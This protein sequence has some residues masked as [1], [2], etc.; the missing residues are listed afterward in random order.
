MA[1]KS[2]DDGYAM[3]P[4]SLLI[5]PTSADCNLNCTYCFYLEKSKLYPDTKRHRMSEAVLESMIAKYMAT[6]QPVYYFGWQGGEPTLMGIDFFR[7]AVE[8]QKKYGQW[9]ATVSNGLQTNATLINDDLAAL[10]SR[11]KF[12]VG[13]S[14][15]GPADIH[16]RY[17]QNAGGRCSQSFDRTD[18]SR[19]ARTL[20][21][22]LECR[23]HELCH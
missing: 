16:D 20:G 18:F 11:Y 23:S 19:S 17:R 14:I 4:F 6:S 22:S 21:G 3:T 2:A 13:V 8:L 5:K 15:D 12:L 10:F 1:V 9:G 7:K